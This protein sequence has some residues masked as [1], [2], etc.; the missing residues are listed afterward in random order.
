MSKASLELGGTNWGTK[1]GNLL[2]YAQGNESSK[3]VP[4]EFSFTRGSDIAATR[5]N[6]SGLIEKYRENLLLHSNA[7]NNWTNSNT[8][9]TSGQIG[10]DGSSDAWLLEKSL[11]SGFIFRSFSG[12]GVYTLSLY[13]KAGTLNSVLLLILAS[14]GN[15]DAY[16]NLSTGVVDTFGNNAFDAQIEDV[17]GGWYRCSLIGNYTSISQVRIYPANNQGI[18][19]TSGTI[20]I[21]DAQVE[22]GLVATSYLESGATKATSG[23]AD[24]EPRINYAGGTASLLLE[25][26]RTNIVPQSEYLNGLNKIGTTITTNETTSPEGIENANKI[27]ANGVS[28]D[29]QLYTQSISFTSGTSYSISIFAKADTNNF[30]QFVT[31]GG[32][33][34]NNAWANFDLSNGTTGTIGSDATASME[35]YGNGWYRCILTATATATISSSISLFMITSATAIRGESNALSTSSFL[36]GFQVEAGSYATSYIPTYGTSV[37]RVQDF[38]YPEDIVA[39]PIVFGANDDFTLYYE[40]S[41]DELGNNM[42]MGGGNNGISDGS[43]RSYWWVT[44]TNMLLRGD[45]EVSIATATFNAAKN[46]NYK[47]LVKRNGSQVDFYVDGTKIPTTQQTTN[48]S[49]T[50]RSVGWSY[51]KNIYLVK[52][53]IKQVKVFPTTLTDREAVDLTSPYSTYQELVTAEGLTW[54]SPTCTT[55]S[56]TELQSI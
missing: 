50:L 21:Q 29:H 32:T 6:S 35:D 27:T 22:Q 5:V 8:T 36:Y 34:S 42:L 9:E 40:G 4:R 31:H 10:Y 1:D 13:A 53:N 15:G 25:P 48:T 46:T 18:A 41:F 19:D 26:Q 51:N 44:N 56:I 54:E 37:T 28:G 39:N 30:I 3:F 52:G 33:F 38:N 24:N 45:G 49:F 16:F 11:A 23:V 55:N 14:G 43:G 17:G 20:Y 2:G 47:L 7:F 12:S